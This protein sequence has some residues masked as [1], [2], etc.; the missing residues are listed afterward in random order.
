MAREYSLEGNVHRVAGDPDVADL[1]GAQRLLSSFH[2]ATRSK[3]LLV[4]LDGADPVELPEVDGVR[5][6]TLRLRLLMRSFVLR[7]RKVS[8]VFLVGLW[9][10]ML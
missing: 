9:Q 2:R 10:L 4:G 3:Y 5:S 1:A 6:Q 7:N 8:I